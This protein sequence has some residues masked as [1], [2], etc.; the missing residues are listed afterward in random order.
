[1]RRRYIANRFDVAGKR[2]GKGG[3]VLAANERECG[4]LRSG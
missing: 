1:M 2:A 3:T 4:K